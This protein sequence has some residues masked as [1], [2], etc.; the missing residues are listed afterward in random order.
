MSLSP[1]H[2]LRVAAAQTHSHLGD[3]EANLK[4]HLAI[5]DAA[6]SQGIEVLL[7][8]EMSLTGHS[9]GP[10]TPRLAITRDSEQVRQLAEAA[11]SMTVI[12]GLIEEG[13]AAQF[14]NS[15]FA[16][17]EGELIFIH[18]KL[19]LATYGQ[20]EDGKY[21][22][23]GRFVETIHFDNAWRA[24]LLICNDLWNPAMVHLAALH[25]ATLLFAPISSAAEAVGG[26][27]DNP[28]N[29]EVN[30]R[31]YAMT[32]GM[33]VVMANR[34]GRE[35]S[36]SF[37]GGSRILDPF[38]RTLATAQGDEPQLVVADLNYER[39]RE[40]RF[41]LPTVRD[42]NLS[43]LLREGNRLAETIGIPDTIRS[44]R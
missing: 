22:A 5:I 31:F 8:P 20:L 6:R 7:F 26:E 33:P 40:A 27:F 4:D 42:S 14:Y 44:A 15:A 19:S 30:L 32:Y 39:V 1:R 29:W 21:F 25:G 38:G 41:L 43:L 24:G 16:V 10:D 3:L 34:V 23:A 12:F 36:L 11:G 37:W 18:R 9:A 28:G 2:P 13:I 35:G 17:R